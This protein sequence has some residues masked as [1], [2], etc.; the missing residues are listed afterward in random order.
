MAT[1]NLHP[2]LIARFPGS[3]LVTLTN[4]DTAYQFRLPEGVRLEVQIAPHVNDAAVILDDSV[5]DGTTGLT[6]TDWDVVAAGAKQSYTFGPDPEQ[7]VPAG[8][9]LSLC[10]D[11]AGTK[12]L[13]TVGVA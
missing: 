8:R 7:G 5:D 11:T 3:T 2:T 10:T 13:I 9:L 6:P 1:T 4:A 12:V